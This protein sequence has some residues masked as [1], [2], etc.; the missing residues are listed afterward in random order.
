[1]PPRPRPVPRLRLEPLGDR[2]L[3]A[4]ARPVLFVP[5]QP[6]SLPISV[7]QAPTP[8]AQ[9]AAFD[10]FIGQLG[11]KP[12]ELTSVFEVDSS[13]LGQVTSPTNALV[14][15]LVTLGG[16]TLYEDDATANP[17]L[18]VATQDWRMQVAPF[19]GVDDGTLSNLTAQGIA[20]D[21]F[22]TDLNGGSGVYRY[23][24]DYLGYWMMKAMDAWVAAGGDPSVGVDVIS[25]SEGHL[26]T[27]AYVSSAAYGGAYTGPGG[28]GALPAVANW[29]SLAGPNAGASG[30]YNLLRNNFS[31]PLGSD[32]A[33]GLYLFEEAAYLRATDPVAPEPI[34]GPDGGVAID[35][36]DV[37]SGAVTPEEFIQL[38][39]GTLRDEMATY[40]FLDGGSVNADPTARN[41]LLLDVNGGADPNG[42]VGNLTVGF[43]AIAGTRLA[44]LTTATSEV[45]PGGTVLA[46]GSGFDEL[47]DV[48]QILLLGTFPPTVAGQAWVRDTEAPRSGDGTVAALSSLDPYA[49]DAR[50]TVL[51]QDRAD[52]DHN[53]TVSDAYIHKVILSILQPGLPVPPPPGARVLAAAFSGA[54]PDTFDAVR[55]TFNQDVDA[56]SFG[57]GGATVTGPGGA[58]AVTGVVPVAGT[59]D[60]FDVT[61]APQSAPGTYTVTVGPGVL[62]P[63]GQLMDQNGNAVNGEA[64]TA[65]G[66]DRFTG[67]GAISV[68]PTA[69][70]AVGGADGSVRILNGNGGAVLVPAFRPLDLPG[71]PRYTGL[72][73]VALGDLNGD[74]VLDLFVAAAQ[75][76]GAQGLAPSRAG[77]V[78]V[79]DGAAL[80]AGAAPV[81][82]HV[83]TPFAATAGPAG[84][85]GRYAN[86]LNIATGDVDGDGRVDLI[87]GTRGGTAAAGRVEFGRVAVVLAGT[88]ADGSDD[89]NI[90]STLTPFGA[91]YA[92]GVVVAA[93]DL[94]G[95]G[96][97][98]VAVTRGGPVAPA[99]PNKS[100]KLKAFR[101]T[102]QDLEELDLN[103]PAAGSLAPF[104][105]VERDARVAFADPDGDGSHLLVFSA[106]DRTD[107]SGTRVRVAAFTV[108]AV[109]GA[110]TAAGGGTGP[111]GSY[112]LGTGVLDHATARV[113]LTGAGRS[114]LAVVTRSAAPGLVYLDPLTG[115]VLPGGFG[116][117][118]LAGGVA[119]A[120][121]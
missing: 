5:G 41:S 101:F 61:F 39:I 97:A 27:R 68:Q 36:L 91:A 104:P 117:A 60:Q 16:Y 95:D 33:G 22:A 32:P 84:A 47:A 115:A 38:Y 44:T 96:A 110:A 25:H 17:T 20:D 93:G 18:F 102:G 73:N 4:V 62:T 114:D 67:S 78:F 118:V 121:A 26:V 107:P 54:A 116:F 49:G 120:G 34:F 29:V 74:R 37:A 100:L 92:K 3:P 87:A 24:V 103:G 66:G 79:Y 51:P 76:V 1:M 98:E 13:V 64:G 119:L 58:V 99:N 112:T 30:I 83:F 70:F 105:A 90:G 2:C 28:A 7:L 89:S 46:L 23:G 111:S 88:D 35:P 21:V 19:D 57:T 10:A 86:G 106:L 81:V 31:N 6:A 12:W 42:F 14:A 77:K 109:T 9:L 52:I 48:V 71:G 45:G 43:T 55:L 80:L 59:A 75:P 94:D 50:I 40:D 53:A 69:V 11:A 85:T 72:V 56:A 82:L 108:D 113:D 8:A 15:D 65:P 63:A